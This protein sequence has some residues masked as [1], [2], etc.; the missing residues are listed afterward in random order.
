MSGRNVSD[1]MGRSPGGRKLIAVVYADMVG[2]SRLIELD[3]LGTLE[4]LRALRNNLI[5]P[6]INAHGGRLVQTG[7][8]SLLIVFDSIDGAVRCAI[9]IQQ[10]VPDYDSD[11]PPDRAIRFRVGINI[12][13]VIA[14]GT[15][16]HGD[17]VNVAARLQAECPPGGIC[18]S[19]AVHDHVHGRLDLAF[20]ELGVLSLKN[21]SR[22]V[23]A[24]VVR[25][26]GQTPGSASLRRPGL[27]RS[28]AIG[29]PAPG[30]A[31]SLP[32]KPSIAVLPFRNLS[33]H[34]EQEYFV[35]G[36]AQEIITALSRISWLLVIAP[37]SDKARSIAVANIGQELG[38]R[39]ILE[40]SVRQAD[41]RVRITAQLIEAATGARVWA[42][43]FDGSL[44]RVFELQ[45]SVALSIAGV[46]EPALE[47]AETLRSAQRPTNDLSAYDLYLRAL[48]IFSR[49]SKEAIVQAL[50]LFERVIERDPGYGPALSRAACCHLRL[51]LDGWAES[52]TGEREK[53]IDL[54]HRA[55]E[56]GRDDPITITN[57]AY[58]LGEFGEDLDAMMALVDRALTLSPSYARGWFQSGCL[59]L[60]GGLLDVAIEHLELAV[61]LSPRNRL[62]AHFSVIGSAH[63]FAR[64]F[65]EAAAKLSVATQEHPA[66]PFPYRLLAS[67][68]A[69]MGRLKE[70][71]EVVKQLSFITPVAVPS[72]TPYRNQDHRE[73]FLSGLRLA[74]GADR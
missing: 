55:L 21:I 28:E 51:Y 52:L 9:I 30:V 1:L 27:I 31:V 36:M 23:E 43:H 50:D 45:D 35:D 2:Y 69:H 18:V 17:G 70:A 65:E 71:R 66:H 32:N 63:L 47:V 3:D 59:R 62:G 44:E 19:R 24:F 7:G 48:P 60:D 73:L 26:E 37:D 67:C 33:G 10:Q 58:A 34:P 74:V 61:R 56:V 42:D 49:L 20:D 4:R 68:Y 41:Q 64:R 13:D 11:Q 46:I 5:D 57:A 29:P 38:A 8:D 12:G 39:Y 14:D 40:G 15:D 16:L 72:V 22:P 54:A 6:A 53:G 25:R